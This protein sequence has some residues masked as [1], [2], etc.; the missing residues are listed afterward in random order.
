MKRAVITV[1]ALRGITEILKVKGLSDFE[2]IAY[3]NGQF[4]MR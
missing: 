3:L 4:G 2:V 1:K